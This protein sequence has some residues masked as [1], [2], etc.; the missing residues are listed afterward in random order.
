MKSRNQ[1]GHNGLQWATAAVTAQ[2]GT[3]NVNAFNQGYRANKLKPEGPTSLST[4]SGA[5]TW[6]TAEV[7]EQS[8]QPKR[9]CDLTM[10]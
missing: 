10:V 1:H 3:G 6:Q 7:H 2:S 8:E 4:G 9:Y 5:S